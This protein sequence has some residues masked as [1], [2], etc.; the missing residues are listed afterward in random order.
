MTVPPG[1]HTFSNPSYVE[2]DMRGLA[3]PDAMHILEQAE[4]PGADSH[5]QAMRSMVDAYLRTGPQ[6]LSP[7]PSRDY[8]IAAP[9]PGAVNAAG[10]GVPI[11][12]ARPEKTERTEEAM[13][14]DVTVQNLKEE[15]ASLGKEGSDQG[16]DPPVVFESQESPSADATIL[17]AEDAAPCAGDI[18][19]CDEDTA[20]GDDSRDALASVCSNIVGG[21]DMVA[22]DPEKAKPDCVELP[23]DV[24]LLDPVDSA[25][26]VVND[27]DGCPWED[28]AGC[29]IEE[30]NGVSISLMPS[31]VDDPQARSKREISPIAF[32]LPVSDDSSPD[33]IQ[34][35]KNVPGK[36]LFFTLR[37]RLFAFFWFL[38]ILT[39][40]YCL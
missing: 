24:C 19:D 40:W 28:E 23:T 20:S 21:Q 4:F 34:G 26:H 35:N 12:R 37:W 32:E 18:E 25:K 16:E 10:R 2:P 33:H 14:Q 13:D 1:F 22:E 27:P 8:C 7:E 39:E 36:D 11:P 17:G 15:E 30:L 29:N 6:K 5:A 31:P 38:R 3:T 9:R